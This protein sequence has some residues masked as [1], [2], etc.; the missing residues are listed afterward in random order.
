[1]IEKKR[2]ESGFP[3]SLSLGSEFHLFH[4]C[5]LNG[6]EHTEPLV[7][8]LRAG[9]HLQLVLI[10]EQEVGI[11]GTHLGTHSDDFRIGVIF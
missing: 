11:D 7:L 3:H 6:V 9:S 10:E 1:M 5:V 4:T 2:R 8:P